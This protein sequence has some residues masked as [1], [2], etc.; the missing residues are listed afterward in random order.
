MAFPPVYF[1]A[2]SNVHSELLDGFES[3]KIIGRSF[4]LA[5]F[6][7]MDLSKIP[8]IVDNPIKI[9][10]LTYSTTS[11]KDLNC[12]PLLSSREKYILC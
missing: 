7:R 1:M 9:V 4:S 6:C 3:G 2:S 10:G 12:S 5:I 8:R 11:G